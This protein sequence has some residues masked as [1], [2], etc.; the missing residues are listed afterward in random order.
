MFGKRIVERVVFE[1]E[2][3]VV[4]RNLVD[5]GE[6]AQKY[7]TGPVLAM[8][9]LGRRSCDAAGAVLHYD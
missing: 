9:E 2:G 3:L 8:V 4:R 1:R 7:S 5:D 6:D